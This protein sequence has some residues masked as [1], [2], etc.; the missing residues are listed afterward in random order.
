MNYIVYYIYTVHIVNTLKWGPLL[1]II[2][3]ALLNFILWSFISVLHNFLLNISS[4][5]EK[6]SVHCQE[7]L[8]THHSIA[9]KWAVTFYQI[10]Y[11]ASTRLVSLLAAK[12][13][14]SIKFLYLPK[15]FFNLKHGCNL[16]LLV[17]YNGKQLRIFKIWLVSLN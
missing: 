3:I 11:Q 13:L 2:I 8:V 10:S 15:Y 7:S 14:F 5:K 4:S 1:F 17:L 12:L 16:C 9:T 6:K